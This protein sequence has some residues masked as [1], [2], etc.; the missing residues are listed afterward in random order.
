MATNI[1][2]PARQITTGTGEDVRTIGRPTNEEAAK[3][4]GKLGRLRRSNDPPGW[5][6]LGRALERLLIMEIGW[7]LHRDAIDD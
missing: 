2:A 1:A 4:L 6:I 3:A 5:A 7:N